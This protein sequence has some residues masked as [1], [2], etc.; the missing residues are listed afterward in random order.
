MPKRLEENNENSDE[1]TDE[2]H[3]GPAQTITQSRYYTGLNTT[4]RNLLERITGP[5]KIRAQMGY[6]K[7]ETMK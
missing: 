6:L 7:S 2:R 1:M 4:D 5:V 3:L